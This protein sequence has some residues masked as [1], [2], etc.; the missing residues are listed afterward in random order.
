MAKHRRRIDKAKDRPNTQQLAH[1]SRSTLKRR[2]KK[3]PCRKSYTR[4]QLEN[5][6]RDIREGISVKKASV[7]WSIPRTTLNDIKLGRYTTSDRPGP[8]PVLACDEE[9]LL[10][11]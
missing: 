3:T 10:E 2:L 4:E 8:D 7:K 9:Q 5:A 1:G 6:M 11:E